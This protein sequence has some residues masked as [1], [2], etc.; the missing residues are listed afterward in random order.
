MFLLG[1]WRRRTLCP[2]YAPC[3]KLSR[4]CHAFAFWCFEMFLAANHPGVEVL[5][6]FVSKSLEHLRIGSWVLGPWAVG[7]SHLV[8]TVPNAQAWYGRGAR[9][10]QGWAAGQFEQGWRIP[11]RSPQALSN[12]STSEVLDARYHL[13]MV[14]KFKKYTKREQP[15]IFFS[16]VALLK[17]LL[18]MVRLLVVDSSGRM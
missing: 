12:E 7:L 6:T 16:D 14:K 13:I 18:I 5:G 3:M 9:C 2:C 15:S 8:P 17:T 11:R 4:Q 10:A 1:R